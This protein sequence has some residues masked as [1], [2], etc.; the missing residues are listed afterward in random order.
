M[1]SNQ[2][3]TAACVAASVTIPGTRPGHFKGLF[4]NP[5][6]LSPSPYPSIFRNSPN[7]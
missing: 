6:P 5:S 2:R 7:K 3:K 4:P 1:A